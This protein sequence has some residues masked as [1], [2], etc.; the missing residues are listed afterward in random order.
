MTNQEKWWGEAVAKAAKRLALDG[1]VFTT[2]VSDQEYAP[3]SGYETAAHTNTN[4]LAKTATVTLVAKFAD[5]NLHDLAL[6]EL[7]HVLLSEHLGLVLETTDTMLSP[8]DKLVTDEIWWR[9]EESLVNALARLLK[10]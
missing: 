7:C 2:K 4:W 9:S 5:S 10:E 3:H 1:W 6:H 8:G